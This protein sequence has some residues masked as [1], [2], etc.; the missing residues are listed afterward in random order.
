M[1]LLEYVDVFVPRLPW[2]QIHNEQVIQK[3]EDDVRKRSY[4]NYSPPKTI[5]DPDD[6]DYIWI[7]FY[8]DNG[9]WY[10][11]RFLNKDVEPKKPLPPHVPKLVKQVLKREWRLRQ[12]RMRVYN[13][14]DFDDIFN[15]WAIFVKD[16]KPR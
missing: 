15:A 8:V 11:K 6:T 2:E 14:K 16:T 10:G 5:K 12:H 4:N 13:P 7:D 3:I 1:D 9:T